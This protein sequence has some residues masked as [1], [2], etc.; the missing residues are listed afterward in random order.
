MNGLSDERLQYALLDRTSFKPFAGLHSKGQV[1][2]Q[3]A[4]WKYRN[5]LSQSGRIDELVRVFKE[6]LAVHDYRLQTGT[7][8]DSSV[9]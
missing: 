6:L 4:L 5:R 2:D 1:P 9:V 8:V 3:K 7:L